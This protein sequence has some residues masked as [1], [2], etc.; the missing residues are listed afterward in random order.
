MKRRLFSLVLPV[1]ITGLAPV[2]LLADLSEVGEPQ[3][4]FDTGRYQLGYEIYL[5]RGNLAA[6]YRVAEKAVRLQPRDAAWRRRLAE[7]AQWQHLSEVAL[8]NWLSLARMTGDESA[9]QE[10]GRLAPMLADDEAWLAWQEHEARRHPG[11]AARM[12]SL[13]AAF[14]RVGR[15]REGLDFLAALRREYPR[16]AV[17]EADSLLAERSG[18]D[19]RALT[20]LAWLNARHGP[21]EDWLLR[22]AALHYQRGDLVAA[23]RVLATA[24]PEM[25]AS[26]TAYWRT[27]AEVARLLGD[28]VTARRAYARV[29]AS[30]LASEADLINYAALLQ[31]SQPL[32][33]AQVQAEAFQ[34]FGRGHAANTALYL[35][36]SEG[37]PELAEA[38]LAG[39]DAEQ[40]AALQA[41]PLF[42]ELRGR[43]HEA[44]GRWREAMADFAAGLA[45]APGR[46]GL[47]QAWL[48]QVI[49]R[50]RPEALRKMLIEKRAFAERSPGVWSLWAAGWSR[51]DDA[52]QALPWLERRYQADPGNALSAL[53][54][55]DGLARAGLPEA[56]RRVE[57]S[58]WQARQQALAGLPAEQRR[59]LEQALLNMELQRLPVDSGRRRLQALL[60]D[61]RDATGRVAPWVRELALGAVWA[62]DSADSLPRDVTSRLPVRPAA[63][64]PVWSPLLM[65]LADNDKPALDDLIATRLDELPIY[66]RVEAAERLGRF[67]LAATL[68]FSSAELRQDDDE[69][70]RRFQ[71]R[72]WDDGSWADLSFQHDKQGSLTRTP[73]ALGW[74]GHV[75]G[76]LALGLRA[77]TAGLSSD[78]LLLRLPFDSQQ[79]VELGIG[80][81]GESHEGQL[82]LTSMHSLDSVTGL[83]G[84]ISLLARTGV[85]A[86]L[87]AGWRQESTATSGLSVGGQRDFVGGTLGWA[88]SG[89]D[90]LALDLEYSHFDAQGG[91]ALGST[92]VS[93]LSVNHRLFSGIRDWVIK[94]GVSNT[95]SSTTDVL[96]DVLKPLLPAG[97]AAG[98]DYFVPQGYTQFSL[99]LAFG[100]NAEQSYQRGWHSFWEIGLT[101]DAESGLGYDYRWGMLGRVLGGDRLRIYVDGADGAQGNGEATQTFA[102]DYRLFY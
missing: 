34:R 94:A 79:R 76:N 98:P 40:M 42:L 61:S 8:A 18:A 37:R 7:V 88:I 21:Q 24:E 13:L 54:Y 41:D 101:Q 63:P 70:Q 65:A 10:V 72:A 67:D 44:E 19:E 69:M 96:P 47:Q 1:L 95:A 59:A 31:G 71:Q 32:L 49:E 20:D 77:E 46:P 35:W 39:L 52:V 93:G 75:D 15:P 25:P 78:P 92:L 5:A 45:L 83:R 82:W 30:G 14:E 74:K 87:R 85:D 55:A 57:D 58:V 33:A 60:K 53:A 102:V 91:G 6:A 73:L 23:G 64:V 66:D 36:Q 43:L 29:Y 16:K 62:S 51:L 81:R 17:V 90:R 86:E 2:T 99:A 84:K 56:A 11:D 97:L 68:A 22:A 9:W 38:F 80:H 12:H 48:G 27:H 4:A 100:E 26:A 50:G 89:R 28:S 3:A